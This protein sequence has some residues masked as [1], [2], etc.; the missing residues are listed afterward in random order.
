M[1]RYLVDAGIRQFLDIGTGIHKQGSIHEVAQ[2]TVPECRVVYADRDP[3]VLARA[4]ALLADSSGTFAEDGDPVRP[5]TITGSP[6][7]RSHLDWD[8]PTGRRRRDPLLS[9][10]GPAPKPPAAPCVR[11]SAGPPAGRPASL[12]ARPESSRTPRPRVTPATTAT[13]AD[14]AP[15]VSSRVLAGGTHPGHTYVAGVPDESS[16]T[17]VASLS[18]VIEPVYPWPEKSKNI[19]SPMV[20]VIL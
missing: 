7:I 3:V 16:W 18:M 13:A 2:R 17:S 20:P 19:G 10:G 5:S 11:A 8:R 14:P 1:V 12:P 9:S 4:R 15:A 6:A